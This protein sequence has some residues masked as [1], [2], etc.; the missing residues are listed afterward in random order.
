MP[1]FF[2][3]TSPLQYLHQLDLLAVLPILVGKVIVP[4]A[5]REELEAGRKLGMNVPVIESLPWMEVRSVRD[6]HLP[7]ER[8]KNLGPGERGVLALA[9]EAS[10]PTVILDD[11]L[12]R[13]TAEALGLSFTGTIGLLIDAKKAGLVEAVEPHLRKLISLR[14][15]LSAGLLA[16]ALELAG[17]T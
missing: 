13:D 14:F 2:C 17:E 3:D 1:E 9:L 10:E 16:M 4:P 15:R 12:A 11:A 5:V 8:S 6:L 7:Q